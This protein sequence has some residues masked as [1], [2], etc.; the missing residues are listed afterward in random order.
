MLLYFELDNTHLDMLQ[1]LS[2]SE[3]KAKVFIH[4]SFALLV[5]DLDLAVVA[6]EAH[7]TGVVMSSLS[8]S[9]DLGHDSCRRLPN[10]KYCYLQMC[11][12]LGFLKSL[13]SVTDH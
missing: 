11:I 3:K 5:G 9:S 2:C 10:V 6:G 7:R 13:S 1:G 12:I 8:Y 4:P